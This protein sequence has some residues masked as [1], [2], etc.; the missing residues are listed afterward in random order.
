M[1]HKEQLRHCVIIYNN[2]IA[3][4][5]DHPVK[6][7]LIYRP[8]ELE[9]IFNDLKALMTVIADE[10]STIDIL[11]SKQRAY[12]K[13]AILYSLYTK[14][15][16]VK[17]RSELTTNKKILKTLEKEV[18]EIIILTEVEWFRKSKTF[19][20]P[21]LEQYLDVQKHNVKNTNKTS[22]NNKPMIEFK[23]SYHGLSVNL[24]VIFSKIKSLFKQ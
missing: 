20:T 22:A 2:W 1:K 24:G 8:E 11:S 19:E 23:P 17:K 4:N 5:I 14:K 7:A 21:R 18:E 9:T 16:D 12:L 15:E 13:S 10:K 6:K 3:E